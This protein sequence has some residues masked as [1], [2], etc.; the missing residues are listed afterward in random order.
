MHGCQRTVEEIGN[1]SVYVRNEKNRRMN[2]LPRRT[3]NRVEFGGHLHLVALTAPTGNPT[4][5]VVI[6][7]SA[8]A[9]LY[10]FNPCLVLRLIPEQVHLRSGM[11]NH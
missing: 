5:R 8:Q 9:L 10:Q 1:L 2:H 11:R 3:F 6:Y 7:I 4:L